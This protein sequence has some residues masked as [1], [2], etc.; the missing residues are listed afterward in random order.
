MDRWKKNRQAE[1]KVEALDRSLAIIE[2]TPDGAILARQREFL[3]RARLRTRANSSASI[4][5]SSSSRKV[6]QSEDYRAFWR[7]LSGG[8]FD[9]GVY[10]RLRKDGSHAYI[11]AT[12]NHQGAKGAVVGVMKVAADVTEAQAQA[13]EKRAKLDG[14]VAAC[15][16]SSNSSRRR[17]HRRQRKFPQDH[18]LSARRDRRPEAIA[19]SSIPSSPSRGLSRVLGASSTP[20]TP[21]SD[22]FHRIGAGGKKVWLQASYNPVFDLDGKVSKVVKFA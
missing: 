7:K 14:A 16:P 21:W 6:V 19:C 13:M 2:F 17:N 20:A 4:T 9:F 18:G 10:K 8:A 12:Y 3:P 11:Q 15:R 5:A 1:M 22:S